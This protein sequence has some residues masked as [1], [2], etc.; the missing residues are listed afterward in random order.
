MNRRQIANLLVLQELKIQPRLDLFRDR[1]VIQKAIYLAQAAGVDLG[2]YY[3]WYLHGPYCSSLTKDMFG[4]AMDPDGVESV[5]E[6]YALD[7]LSKQQLGRLGA[8][9]QAE[10]ENLPRRLEFFASVHYLIDRQQV[11]DDGPKT[12]RQ[13][14]K[15]FDKD[16][17]EVEVQ[18]AI[19]TLRDANLLKPAQ[20]GPNRS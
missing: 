5:Q 6:R 1:L 2:Y 3:G 9:M 19:K 4:A 11:P 18:N 17:S 12:L 10:A 8:L 7:Q 13:R 16:F 14:L 20:R 15:A